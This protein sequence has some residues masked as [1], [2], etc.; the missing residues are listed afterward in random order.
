MISMETKIIAM[1]RRMRAVFSVARSG[2]LSLLLVSTGM[3]LAGLLPCVGVTGKASAWLIPPA[4]IYLLG[5]LLG[6]FTEII[7]VHQLRDN[8]SCNR[9]EVILGMVAALPGSILALLVFVS[10]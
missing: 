2:L 8:S 9:H 1:T 5:V 10:W 6:C 3:L 7:G 4:I